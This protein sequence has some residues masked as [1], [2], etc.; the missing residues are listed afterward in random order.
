M[1]L[2]VGILTLAIVVLFIIVDILHLGKIFLL[3]NISVGVSYFLIIFMVISLIEFAFYE[4]SIVITYTIIALFAFLLIIFLFNMKYKSISALMSIEVIHDLPIQLVIILVCAILLSSLKFGMYGMGGDQGVYLQNAILLANGQKKS[5]VYIKEYDLL[6]DG[7]DRKIFMESLNNSTLAGP[8][9]Y[10]ITAN[11]NLGTLKPGRQPENSA[12]FHGLPNMSALLSISGVIL[13]I[14]HIMQGLTLPYIITILLVFITLNNNLR[15]RIST[16]S[17]MTALYSMSPNLL[18]VSKSSLTEIYLTM[19]ISLFLFFLTSKYVK[20]TWLL[21]IP[22]LGFSFFHVSIYTI[23]PMF[24][25]LFM[26]LVLYRRELGAW[27]SGSLSVLFYCIGYIIMCFAAP[28]YTFS[29]YYPLAA[30]I[31]RFGITFGKNSSQF[32][33][34]FTIVSITLVLFAFIYYYVF[35]KGKGLQTFKGQH[36]TIISIM[37]LLSMFMLAFRWI[38]M[39]YTT[40]ESIDQYNRFYGGGIFNTLPNLTLFSYGFGTG[41]ILLFFILSQFIYK[42]KRLSEYEILPVTFFFWYTI[43]FYCAFLR[44]TVWNYYYSTRYIVPYLAI[45]SILGGVVFDKLLHRKQIFVLLVSALMMLPFSLVLATNIDF[46]D[47]DIISHREIMDSINSCQSGSIVVLGDNLNR[48]LFNEISANTSCYVFPEELF[49]RFSDKSFMLGRSIFYISKTYQEIDGIPRIGKTIS[50][51]YNLSQWI[52]GWNN[53]PKGLLSPMIT[54]YNV[55]IFDYTDYLRNEDIT[56]IPMTMNNRFFINSAYEIGYGTMWTSSETSFDFRFFADEDYCFRVNLAD[57]PF[58]EG[59]GELSLQFQLGT[60]NSTLYSTTV[61][62]NTKYI[63]YFVSK[64]SLLGRDHLLVM[65]GET[66]KPSEKLGN[67]D[68]RD[69]GIQITSVEAIPISEIQLRNAS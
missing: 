49:M 22:V 48:F 42:P 54:K 44:L 57:W 50:T 35:I 15:L 64:S 56:C 46:T 26:G 1:N 47:M 33:T 30:I 36:P 21:S 7:N 4:Y 9:F 61:Y 13:G 53:G 68:I 40:P 19:I 27:V 34:V 58:P 24:V 12:I 51:N 31:N 11:A 25:L 38:N 65:Y 3:R 29:D 14:E 23:M 18:W 43:I 62:N 2:I 67:S 37:T 28:L 55:S 52:T 8:G 5:V 17:A 32:P 41:F 59:I 6:S 16:S 66:W 20:D 63:D 39:A 69:L 60:D 10:N 45:I